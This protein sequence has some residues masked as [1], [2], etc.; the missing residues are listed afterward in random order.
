M[1]PEWLASLGGEPVLSWASAPSAQVAY[2]HPVATWR[3]FGAS[4][5]LW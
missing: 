5:K 2:V 3:C 4:M 1:A